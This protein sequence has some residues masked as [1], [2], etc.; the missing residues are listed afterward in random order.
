[1]IQTGF[2]VYK[3]QNK[4]ISR[5]IMYTFFS[6]LYQIKSNS[7]KINIILLSKSIDIN[8]HQIANK[9]IFNESKLINLV[10]KKMAKCGNLLFNFF[11]YI[12]HSSKMLLYRNKQ[13]D[14]QIISTILI[15]S[16]IDMIFRYEPDIMSDQNQN[17]MCNQFH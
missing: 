13:V 10:K 1:M 16:T 2:I 9:Q 8:Q 3:L 14:I 5:T 4:L 11:F 12:K 17:N 15:D 7:F 6:N